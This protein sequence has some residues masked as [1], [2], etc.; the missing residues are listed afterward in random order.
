M[1]K[2]IIII[3]VAALV[4]VSLSLG[5]VFLL[6]KVIR[7][8]SQIGVKKND[9]VSGSRVSRADNTSAESTAEEST[10]LPSVSQAQSSRDTKNKKPSASS[11]AS[12][13]TGSAAKSARKEKVTRLFKP[14]K[15]TACSSAD[16]TEKQFYD[17]KSGKTLPY[18]IYIPKNLQKGNKTPILFLLHGAGER[19]E[20]NLTQIRNFKG[21]FNAAGDIISGSIILAPQC[22]SSGWWSLDEDGYGDEMGWLGAAW[23]LLESVKSEYGGDPDRIYITG[24][25]MGGIATWALIDRYPE[26]F[27]AAVP[28]CGIGNSYSAYNLTDIPIKIYHGTVDTTIN[29]SASDEMYYAILNAGGTMVDYIRL[30]GVG[31]NAWDAAYSDRDMFCWMFAQTGPKARK[32]DDSYTYKE[33]IKLVS[34]QNIEIFSEKDI[35]FYMLESSVDGDYSVV[36]SLNSRVYDTL[37]NAYE[38]NEGKEFT[39]YYYGKKLYSFIPGSEPS[40]GE[41]VFSSSVTDYLDDLRNY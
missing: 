21:M 10:G 15:E 33:R 4:S 36:A 9:T 23:R 30:Y 18:R 24:L 27:A 16:L 39:V 17:S 12:Q 19:G 5:A 41:F 1:V 40:C 37:R 25:S 20:D 31:H 29:C 26:Q 13:Q 2:R 32:G 34:P 3:S 28:V 7:S 14:A 11:K 38:S 8:V 6:P 22:P 35:D